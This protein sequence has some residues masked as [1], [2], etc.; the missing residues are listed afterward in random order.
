MCSDAERERSRV[1]PMTL[2][3]GML[4]ILSR[5]A[6]SRLIRGSFEGLAIQVLGKV[7]GTALL[8]FLTHTMTA[9][10][11]GATA[12]ARAWPT[13]LGFLLTLGF[14]GS[15]F[16]F[17]PEYLATKRPGAA[18]GYIQWTIVLTGIVGLLA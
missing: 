2:W 13:F 15:A 12:Y 4:P 14:A 10:D 8:L 9:R 7:F 16:R 5:V 11:F 18:V 6:A 3:G 17:L 1:R